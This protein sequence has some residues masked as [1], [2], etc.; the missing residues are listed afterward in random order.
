VEAKNACARI[1][2]AV[3]LGLHGVWFCFMGIGLWRAFGDFPQTNEAAA[4]DRIDLVATALAILGV[5]V[6]IAA[7]SGFWV[8]RREAILSAE[9]AAR[10][11]VGKLMAKHITDY[12]ERTNFDLLQRL[13]IVAIQQNPYIVRQTVMGGAA[14]EDAG[15]YPDAIP[16]KDPES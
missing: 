12:F 14:A 10:D 7:I 16:P 11:E 13:L 4:A 5:V 1:L 9:T 3:A 6:A 15:G 8:V 2:M